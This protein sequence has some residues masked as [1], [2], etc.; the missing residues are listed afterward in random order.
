[1]SFF[2]YQTLHSNK[3]NTYS[4]YMGDASFKILTPQK[5]NQIFDKLEGV[6][7]LLKKESDKG[8]RGELY[9]YL[10]SKIVTAGR[11]G[12]LRTPRHIIRVMVKLLAPVTEDH[13]CDPACGTSGFLMDENRTPS[14]TIKIGSH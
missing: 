8:V 3:N 5:L 13:I 12:Q 10:L 9:E 6:Y 4:K 11:N 14:F 1:M 7:E 2:F